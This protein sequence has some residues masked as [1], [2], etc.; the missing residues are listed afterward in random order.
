MW[1]PYSDTKRIQQ[2]AFFEEN[3]LKLPDF[4]LKRRNTFMSKSFNAD[5][6]GGAI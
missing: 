3:L 6:S 5:P 1:S 2:D 4:I